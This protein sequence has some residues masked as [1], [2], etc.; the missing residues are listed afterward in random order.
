MI[1]PF[2]KG[3]EIK[4]R[5]RET[6]PNAWRLGEGEGI[7]TKPGDQAA[8]GSIRAVKN[9]P[10]SDWNLLALQFAEGPASALLQEGL[11]ETG[12]LAPVKTKRTRTTA[13]HQGQ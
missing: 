9:G 3:R 10:A 6:I 8:F 13:A 7:E 4:S 11:R 12:E 1:L 2:T 5:E